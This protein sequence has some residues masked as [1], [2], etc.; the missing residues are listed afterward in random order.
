M[1]VVV[2]G[3][4]GYIGSHICVELLNNGIDVIVIDNLIN[5]KEETVEEIEQITD[6]R[7]YFFKGDVCD[8][9]FLESVFSMY[10]LDAIIHCANLKFV[11]E[12]IEKPYEYYEKNLLS[13]LNLIYIAE[14]YKIEKFIF[15]SSAS[16]YGCNAIVPI[17]ETERLSSNNPYGRTKII[18][19]QILEDYS[20][21]NKTFKVSILRYFNPMG[22]HESGLLRDHSKAKDTS[23]MNAIIKTL[24][25]EQEYLHVFG[26]DYDTI[27]GT[28]VRDYIHIK[29]L[30]LGHIAAL[31]ALFSSKERFNCYN[32][33]R[34]EGYSVLKVI[35]TFQEVNKTH[36]PYKIEGRRNG[37][38]A[39]SYADCNKAYTELKWKAQKNLSEM[40]KIY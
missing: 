10:R 23:L 7:L 11:N 16:V 12:S 3:G 33:G 31:D 8:K 28:C 1:K 21:T 35:K 17:K 22:W 5:A 40:C 34:G 39:S 26:D 29:D 30:A 27:D 18:Q 4:L 37:D 9:S 13:T 6:K 24:N 14:K 36:I 19:E 25:M 32:L 2:T 20:K 38:I 15:S